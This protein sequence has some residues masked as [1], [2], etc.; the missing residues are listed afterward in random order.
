MF[1]QD[2]LVIDLVSKTYT[3]ATEPELF[4][5]FEIK[6]GKVSRSKIITELLRLYVDDKVS[7]NIPENGS[8]I[9]ESIPN[10]NGKNCDT[11]AKRHDCNGDVDGNYLCW[12]P[13]GEEL[14][15]ARQS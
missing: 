3:V 6:R 14:D 8:D 5:K 10:T 11:C 13:E 2:G 1:Q 9:E 12:K 7:L 4:D 15:N